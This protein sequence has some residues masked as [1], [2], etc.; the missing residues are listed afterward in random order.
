MLTKA[1][2]SVQQVFKEGLESFGIT[3]GQYM[4]LKCLW[5]ENGITVKH[6]ADRLQ[7]DSSTITGILDRLETKQL[8]ARQPDKNDRRALN[9]VL[10]PQGKDLQ[11]PVDQA[12]EAANHKVLN[13]LDNEQAQNFKAILHKIHPAK[14]VPENPSSIS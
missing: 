10:T 9:V 7:L 14:G 8:I 13:C 12:I 4:V 1:Q 3:P 6:L 5:D 11:E 2:H